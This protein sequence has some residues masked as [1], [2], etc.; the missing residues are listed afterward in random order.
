MIIGANP[1]KIDDQSTLGLLGTSNSLAYRVHEIEKHFHS[2]ERWYG[3]N[4]AGKMTTADNLTPWRMTANAS[5][6]TYGTEIQLAAAGD[7]TDSDMGITVVRYDI[8]RLAVVESSANDQTYMLQCWAGSGA[9][10]DATLRTE[11]P[12]RT[13]GNAAEAQP[14]DCQM[15]R[16]RQTDKVWGRIKCEAGNATM[17]III[18]VHA[19]AG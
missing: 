1:T 19:Y 7:V 11:I 8:H 12:Y 16:L 4:L 10:G 14:I 3:N 5:A 6:N 18:G 2:I 13:G 17:D 9:F 15:G